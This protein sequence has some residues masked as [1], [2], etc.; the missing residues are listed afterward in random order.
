MGTVLQP[1]PRPY[2]WTEQQRS[3]RVSWSSA[4][5]EGPA[6]LLLPALSTISSRDEWQPF[7]SAVSERPSNPSATPQLISVD[8]PGFG[9]SQ[10]RRL[11]Y[12]TELLARFLVEFRRDCCPTDCG[13]IAAGHA[14]GIALLAAERHG[15]AMREWVLVAPTWRGPLP[16]MVRRRSRA[17]P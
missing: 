7:V 17:F 15:L 16:T 3:L 13:L 10:R 2:D 4:G 8:W 1:A 6:W 14:A 12:D 5:G 9:G 11:P